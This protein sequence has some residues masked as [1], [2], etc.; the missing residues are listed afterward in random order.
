MVAVELEDGGLSAAQQQLE[1]LECMLSMF[2][3]DEELKID[4][5]AKAALED[6]VTEGNGTDKT[7]RFD[8]QI[9]YTVRYK[10]LAF[11]REVPSLTLTCPPGYPEAE[12]MLFEVK[13]PQ[14]SR[15][16]MERLNTELVKL[17]N[18]ACAGREVV[19][20]QLYQLMQEFLTQVQAS[21][22][23]EELQ[24]KA[25]IVPAEETS[26]PLTLGRRAIYF[27]HII[28]SNKR[29]VVKEWASELQLG[30]FSKIGWPGVVIVE[31][32]EPNVQEYVRRLQ[33]LRW[34][35]ITV[36][37]EQTEEL[38]EGSSGDIDSLRRLPHSFYEFP[39]NGMSDLATACRDAGLEELF[40]TTM[41]IYGR[42]EDKEDLGKNKG[43]YTGQKSEK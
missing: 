25:A 11:G 42:S 39:E 2:P 23:V 17:T 16:E 43:K 22:T 19:G 20:L 8:C 32:P 30:G 36:R 5:A 27:H 21:A 34:K 9:H 18:A 33:H 40:L 41:K 26:T 24:S 4:A 3:D 1:E 12:P 13:C 37:G 10:D 14:L 6:F 29:R 28:A 38:T 7:P 15:A 35:Q 31:G